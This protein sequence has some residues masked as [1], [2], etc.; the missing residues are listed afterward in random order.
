MENSWTIRSSGPN[1]TRCIQSKIRTP[2]AIAP[3][4]E[5]KNFLGVQRKDDIT[6][7]TWLPRNHKS[8]AAAMAAL[9]HQLQPYARGR[10][11]AALAVAHFGGGAMCCFGFQIVVQCVCDPYVF[12]TSAALICIRDSTHNI[13]IAMAGGL[14]SKC[15]TR[16]HCAWCSYR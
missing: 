13:C 15:A 10:G 6:S 3:L 5:L 7:S 11:C 2:A 14:A 9:F 16:E 8:L 12:A 4:Q 1:G